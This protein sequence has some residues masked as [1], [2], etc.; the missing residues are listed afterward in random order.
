MSN[1][2]EKKEAPNNNRGT[3]VILE[4]SPPTRNIMKVFLEK[5]QFTVKEFP[6][7]K[8][9]LT[10]LNKENIANVRLIISDVMMPEMDGLT[11]ATEIKKNP[12][13]QN[14]PILLASALSGKEDILNA[15]KAG[16][17]GYLL[18]PLTIKKMLDALKKIFPDHVFREIA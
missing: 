9:A 2:P 15:K 8:E 18:K 4:D 7:G 3:I 11:F 6:N 16:V 14:V 13:Y 12:T 17:S 5:N 10:T 1:P